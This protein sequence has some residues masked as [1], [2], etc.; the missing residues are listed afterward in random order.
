MYLLKYPKSCI[1]IRS[2]L[3]IDFNVYSL[4][5]S[6]DKHEIGVV[7][8]TVFFFLYTLQS[9]LSYLNSN[10]ISAIS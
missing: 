8:S 1:G 3:H 10:R 7:I 2:T 6:D 4:I 5:Y 9:G